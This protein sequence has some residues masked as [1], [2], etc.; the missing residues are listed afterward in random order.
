MLCSVPRD[1]SQ[2]LGLFEMVLTEQPLKM[3]SKLLYTYLYSSWNKR[4]SRVQLFRLQQLMQTHLQSPTKSLFQLRAAWIIPFFCYQIFDFALNTLVAVSIVVYP[5]TIQ[6][7]LQQLVR[8]V[9]Y[10]RLSDNMKGCHPYMLLR[11]T[12]CSF[13]FSLTISLTKR[14][15]PH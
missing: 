2:Q 14:R 11:Y 5:N 3:K 6:D 10:S 8:I 13:L 12:L 7:Y 9:I 1:N 4:L 15:L